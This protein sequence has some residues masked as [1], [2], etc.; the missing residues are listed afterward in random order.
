V[1]ICFLFIDITRLYISQIR[2]SVSIHHYIE[3]KT[4][5]KLLTGFLVSL[6]N[7]EKQIKYLHIIRTSPSKSQSN[8]LKEQR[9]LS[10][11][12]THTPK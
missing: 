2:L 11:F 6:K 8:R 12:P 1:S 5:C 4:T 10:F 7:R 9:T 3:Q